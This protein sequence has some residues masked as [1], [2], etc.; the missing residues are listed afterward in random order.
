MTSMPGTSFETSAFPSAITDA[1]YTLIRD[2]FYKRCGIYFDDSKRYFVDKRIL[3]RIKATDHS[4]FRAY[5]S[6]L[7]FQKGHTELQHLVNL[8]TVNETYFFRE[9]YQMRAMV[10]G[11]LQDIVRH[12]STKDVIRIWSLPCSTGEEAY[13]IAIYLL[14]NWPGLTHYDV[15]IVGSDIDTRV[16]AR[17][18]RAQYNARAVKNLPTH[19]RQKY[20]SYCPETEVYQVCDDLRQSV[21]FSRVNLNDDLS[22]ESFG[23]F[24]LIFCRNLLI[25]FDDVSRQRAAERL[26]DALNPGGILFLGHSES[27]SR[28]SSLF[29]VKRYNDT[30][31]YR[32]DI[33]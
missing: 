10:S 23:K 12:K 24:D 2:Y 21:A 30:T 27:M 17:A 18:T 20:F 15:E 25:Y 26:Y 5:F 14:E 7:R 33:V 9:E 32:K 8:L 28:V 31:G 11:A 4:S 16:L 3:S 6:Y 19:I 13:S 22:M 29:K 1:E